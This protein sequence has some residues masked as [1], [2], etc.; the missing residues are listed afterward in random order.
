MRGVVAT[1]WSD[2]ERDQLRRLAENGLSQ[3]QIATMMGRTKA[4]VHRQF[5]ILGLTPNAPTP[6][7][8]PEARTHPKVAVQ[9]AGATTLPPLPSL[10]MRE[11]GECGWPS[12][13]DYFP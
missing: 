9:R 6:P 1:P 11:D 3:G 2:A 10:S 8:R 13:E 12:P 5:A 4:S 7:K